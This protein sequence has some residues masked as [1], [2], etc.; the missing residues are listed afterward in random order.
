MPNLLAE[1]ARGE[2]QKIETAH[3][4]NSFFVIV[5]NLGR[6]NSKT[7]VPAL[8][9]KSFLIIYLSIVGAESENLPVPLK[10]ME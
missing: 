5:R 10:P 2:M 7:E 1:A 4:K 6:Y 3:R 8:H 9:L